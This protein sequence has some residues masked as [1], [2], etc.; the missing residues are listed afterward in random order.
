MLFEEKL[1]QYANRED[2]AQ[3]RVQHTLLHADKRDIC[4]S[5][6]VRGLRMTVSIMVPMSST[7]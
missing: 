6:L 3:G 4:K 7:R 1:A 5:D 2:F